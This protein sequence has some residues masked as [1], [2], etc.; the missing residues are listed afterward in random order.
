MATK[1]TVT[2]AAV[3][4]AGAD[5]VKVMGLDVDITKAGEDIKTLTKDMKAGIKLVTPTD[6]F[7]KATNAV[8]AALSGGATIVAEEVAAPAATGGAPKR[9]TAPA[10][11]VK[12]PKAPKAPKEPAAP[13]YRRE[14]AVCDAISACKKFTPEKDAVKSADGIYVDNGGKS[15]IKQSQHVYDTIHRIMVHLQLAEVDAEKGIRAL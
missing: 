10:A 2:L 3:L 7:S 5:M 15:N 1:A 6:K 11:A 14:Y 8:I 9:G 12:A 13:K 4:A